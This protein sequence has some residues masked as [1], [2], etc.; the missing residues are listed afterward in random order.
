MKSITK[1][2]DLENLMNP[3]RELM[4][5]QFNDALRII[6]IERLGH[7]TT[8]GVCNT[9]RKLETLRTHYHWNF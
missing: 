7:K 9:A 5:A 1:L 3:D 4:Y 8:I 6:E 2:T